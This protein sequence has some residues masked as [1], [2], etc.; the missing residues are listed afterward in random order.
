[1][2]TSSES[3]KPT[4]WESFSLVF[5]V[6]ILL[7]GA[8][9]RFTGLDWDKTYHLHPD[10]RFL[11]IVASQLESV[12]NPL[13]YLRTSESPLNPYNTGQGFYV[14][15]NFPMTVTRYVAE[16]TTAVCATATT[17]P[18]NPPTRCPY[19]FTAY[20]GVRQLGRF[21]SGLVDLIAV[22][23]TFLIG[24]RLYDWRVGLVAAFLQ[25]TAVMPIQQSH[26]FTMD[27]WASSLT[28]IA[29]YAAVRAAGLGD[30]KPEWRS[31]WYVLFGLGLG[32]AVSSRINIAPLAGMIAVSGIIWLERRGFDWPSFFKAPIQTAVTHPDLQRVITSVLLAAVVSLITFRLAQPYAFADST[33]AREAALAE[34]G[35]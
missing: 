15:G 18:D 10:E 3:N 27:N 20:D 6:A 1:M 29:L 22:F 7:L 12:S 2:A 30:E 26:F 9:F 14:Y 23:F 11:T 4:R 35:Q 13:T 28:I 24:R 19:T 8:Y 31:S 34:T 5:L 16:W 32:L 17:V 21:L 25:A 33:I